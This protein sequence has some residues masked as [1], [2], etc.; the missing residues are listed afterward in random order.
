MKFKGQLCVAAVLAVAQAQSYAVDINLDLTSLPSAQG[1]T[2]FSSGAAESDVFSVAG[3]VLSMNGTLTNAAYYKLEGIVNLTLPFTLTATARV[4]SGGQTLAFY[5]ATATQ[6]AGIN[7]SPTTIID[8]TNGTFLASLD[9]TTFHNYKLEGSFTTGVNLYIDDVFITSTSSAAY[10]INMVAFGD[11]GGFGNGRAEITAL[12]FQ[13]PIPE[14]A[15]YML[16]MCG[17]S[18][19]IVR[20]GTR[21]DA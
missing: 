10:P 12:S 3:G 2:Y 5:I 20:F 21:R 4:V 1:W 7:L 6:F 8:E 19:L 11:S 16:L 14:P 18:A 9:T 17:L 13:Q 15:T